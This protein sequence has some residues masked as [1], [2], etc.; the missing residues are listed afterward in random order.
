MNEDKFRNKYRIKSARHP[1]WDYA[2][3]AAYFV[4]ICT[5]GRECYF[6]EIANGQM[7]LSDIGKIAFDCWIE[8]PKHF[9]FVKLDALVIMP[10]HV[11]GIIIIDKPVETQYFTC[12]NQND[13]Y[14]N[15]RDV[16]TQDFASQ[17]NQCNNERNIKTQDF[18]SQN[19]QC[20]NER[21]IETQDFASLRIPKNKFGPQSK[22]LASIIRGFKIGVTKNARQIHADF[23]WQSR[24][25]D[26]I[27]RDNNQFERI[28]TYINNNP[29][30][31]EKDK[32]NKPNM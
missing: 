6:G 26:R 32:M 30:H 24:F 20:N 17:N 16:E 10:N 27:I 19:N 11:H 4:T 28:Q 1:N 23:S 5:K 13:Q 18:A 2:N 3:N 9:P 8:I 29:L 31:W 14:N 15:K 25:H 7:K 12:H 22:N 21:N